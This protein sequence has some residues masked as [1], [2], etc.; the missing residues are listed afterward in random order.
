MILPLAAG[1]TLLAPMKAEAQM[2]VCAPYVRMASEAGWAPQH[3]SKVRALMW[4]ESRCT[5]TVRSR[6]RD[7]GLMQINDIVL[8]DH[9]FR[10]AFPA[11]T[12][13]EQL[14]DPMLNLRVARWLFRVA[15][16]SPWRIR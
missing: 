1:L 16:W 3:L 10:K 11:V 14:R 6:T 7:T 8:R 4:R 13:W 5:P 2:D 12:S 15:G 9:R